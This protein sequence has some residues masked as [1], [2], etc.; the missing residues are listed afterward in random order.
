MNKNLKNFRQLSLEHEKVIHVGVQYGVLK[1]CV[2]EVLVTAI[3]MS[4]YNNIG[5]RSH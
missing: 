3:V 4:Q 5:A 2:C 1:F